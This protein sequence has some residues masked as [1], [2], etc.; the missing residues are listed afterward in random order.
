VAVVKII[1]GEVKAKLGQKEVLL[2]MS[3]W[4]Q[5]GS[6]LRTADKSFVR[7]VFV[8]KSIMNIGPRSEITISKFNGN[9]EA[10]MIDVV[11][12]MV[13][14]QVTKD[15]LKQKDK[16]SSKLFIKTPNAVMGIRGTEF[17]I[18]VS[19]QEGFAPVTSLVMIEGKVQFSDIPQ[20]KDLPSGGN[21][22]D[23][24]LKDGVAVHGGEASAVNTNNPGHPL[25][26]PFKLSVEQLNKIEKT[27]FPGVANKSETKEGDEVKKVILPPGLPPSV[28]ASK[29]EFKAAPTQS[30]G[31]RLDSSKTIP[32]SM[33][34]LQTAIVLPPKEGSQ[35]DAVTGTFVA[36]PDAAVKINPDGGL[37]LPQGMEFSPKGNIV[38]SVVM[39]ESSPDKGKVVQVE[40][41]PPPSNQVSK[42]SL[43]SINQV[44]QKNPELAQQASTLGTSLTMN[45][46]APVVVAVNVNPTGIAGPKP[47]SVSVE[48]P[49]PSVNLA[50]ITTPPTVV[51]PNEV[52]NPSFIGNGGLTDLVNNSTQLPNASNSFTPTEFIQQNSKNTDTNIS[53]GVGD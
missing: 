24:F 34:D 17:T 26:E 44:F 13:R 6:T 9:N 38:I 41:A 15:Y 49:R 37:A 14:S 45:Q 32:G 47:A 4:L 11:K 36:G 51:G 53:I 42:V 3:D 30:Q 52:Y 28:V 18:G 19:H 27:E 50:S 22:M 39:P 48:T 5:V 35:F 8:D 40:V 16:D 1:R 12:G 31:E 20:G 46:L 29:P 2:K 10:G 43:E 21:E 25:V 23:Q 33:I 7:L